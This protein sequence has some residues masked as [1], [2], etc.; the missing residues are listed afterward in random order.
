MLN[1]FK[2]LAVFAFNAFLL[3]SR[4]CYTTTSLLLFITCHYLILCSISAIPAQEAAH[5]AEGLIIVLNRNFRIAL[6]ILLIQE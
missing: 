1:I 5:L 3:K 2:I 4:N 6:G